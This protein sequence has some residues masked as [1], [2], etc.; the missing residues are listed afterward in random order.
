MVST[1]LS[2]SVFITDLL[3]AGLLSSDSLDELE[4]L[5]LLAGDLDLE[6]ELLL[7]DRFLEERFKGEDVLSRTLLSGDDLVFGDGDRFAGGGDSS[8]THDGSLSLDVLP[9]GDAL[10][11]RTTRRSI[12]FGESDLLLGGGDFSFSGDGDFSLS[13]T[14]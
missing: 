12:R 14:V 2:D 1:F 8:F 6:L 7:L 4:L 3:A 11:S 5:D 9:S 10:L 13:F